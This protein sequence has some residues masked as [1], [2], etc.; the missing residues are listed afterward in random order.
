MIRA[1]I[2]AALTLFA[3]APTLP[4][5]AAREATAPAPRSYPA[6]ERI[7][8]T[9]GAE[10]SG[11]RS[12]NQLRFSHEGST[13][14]FGSDDA[15]EIAGELAA[16]SLASPGEAVSFALAREAGALACTGRVV[17]AGRAA[18][19]CRFDPNEGYIAE[20]A[21]RG[22]VPE[23]S[24]EVLVLTLVDGRI[25]LVDGLM[26]LGYRFEDTGDLIAVAA[27]DVT[28]AFAGGLR[29]AG[30][31]IDEL[32]DLIAAR[33]LGI[34][35]EWLGAMAHAG[36]PDLDVEQAIQMR[37]LGVTPDYAQRMSR[38]MSA[39]GEIQ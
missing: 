7:D 19:T 30:L 25:A 3:A 6:I 20:L 36:Y 21:R 18:G 28:P 38:V 15:P 16:A 10:S 17:E 12:H 4:Q 24:K 14:S 1:P 27:L 22:L 23:D 35:A 8:W 32:D 31:A 26:H 5:S 33:A 29:D 2:L 37:A 13:S 11:E 39:L 9:Y 34:D